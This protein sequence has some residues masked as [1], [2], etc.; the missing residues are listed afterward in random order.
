M[1]GP[2]P[3]GALENTGGNYQYTWTDAN[4]ESHADFD[5]FD[6]PG[7][8]KIY[9]FLR[10]HETQQVGTYLVTNVYVSQPDNSPPERVDL[11][12]P[13]DGGTVF[14]TTFFAWS[15]TADPDGDAVTYQLEISEAPAFPSADTIVVST[16]ETIAQVEGAQE[17]LDETAY[18]WRVIPVDDYGAQPND[19]DVWQ[20]TTDNNNPAVPGAVMGDVLDDATDAPVANATLRALPTGETTVSGDAGFYFLGGLAQGV[21]DVQASAPGYTSV[22]VDGVIIEGGWYT[23]ADVRLE[24]SGENR[25][26]TLAIVPEREVEVG[27]AVSIQLLG[28]DPDPAD[29]LTYSASGLPSG[30][31]LDS[32]SGLF[33]WTPAESQE[34]AHTITFRVSDDGSPALSAERATTITVVA[35]PEARI[36]GPEFARVGAR[37]ALSFVD[38]GLEGDV[39][40][41]WRHEGTALPGE[42]GLTLVIPEVTRDH[43]G[44]YEATAWSDG[45]TE[46]VTASFYLDVLDALPLGWGV[47]AVGL[48]AGLALLM[49]RK[50]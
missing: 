37:V 14:T 47:G 41:E 29:T 26:P 39:H 19:N 2:I 24:S 7:T 34:G 8:Y 42:D 10:D 49:R 40:C 38:T 12:A 25:A 30:A 33:E 50:R 48:L 16:T 17:L 23:Q 22:T 1:V 6:T 20:F 44:M 15:E 45:K 43:A 13:A 28:G 5:G 21:Y 35:G 46:T 3:A 11:V 32:S 27:D 9:Y 31:S 18:Y 36:E 4:L